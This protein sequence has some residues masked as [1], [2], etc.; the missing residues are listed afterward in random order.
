MTLPAI[1]SLMTSLGVPASAYA[2]GDVAARSPIDGSTLGAVPSTGL[3]E[4]TRAVRKA[5]SLSTGCL[6]FQ[7]ASVSMSPFFTKA[8]SSP[9]RRFSSRTLREKGRRSTFP[10]ESARSASSRNMVYDRGPTV[11][12]ALLPKEFGWVM[13]SSRR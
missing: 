4:V 13:I 10:F 11:R 7:V 5:I 2:Q 3:A 12:V 1:S 9:R 8:P 6:T